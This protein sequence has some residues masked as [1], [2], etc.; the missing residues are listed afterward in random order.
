MNE[1]LC[2]VLKFSYNK[3]NRISA[4]SSP[5]EYKTK[6][7]SLLNGSVIPI[8]ESFGFV[9]TLPWTIEVVLL[10]SKELANCD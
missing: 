1:I 6:S 3:Y 7:F 9:S 2:F 10:G 4:T 5:P 8:Y